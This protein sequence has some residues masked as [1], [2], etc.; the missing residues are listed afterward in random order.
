MIPNAGE[1]IPTTEYLGTR[2]SNVEG[3]LAAKL[4]KEE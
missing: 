2:H 3:I 4:A 1:G